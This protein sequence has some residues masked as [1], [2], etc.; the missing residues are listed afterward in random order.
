MP[1]ERDSF[2]VIFFITL[3]LL[4]A[5]QQ[6]L[7]QRTQSYVYL[8]STPYIGYFIF[9]FFFLL[10]VNTLCNLLVQMFSLCTIAL[11]IMTLRK[12]KCTF[13]KVIINKK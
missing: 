2:K 3:G 4:E 12:I 1:L 10:Y 5:K 8:S 9:L 13:C 6:N 11:P 7:E